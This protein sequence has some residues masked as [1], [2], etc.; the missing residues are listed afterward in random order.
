MTGQQRPSLGDQILR[1]L[2]KGLA[3]RLQEDE[4]GYAELVEAGV[5]DPELFSGMAESGDLKGMLKQ[6]KGGITD[7]VKEHPSVLED[8]DIDP[9]KVLPAEP[10]KEPAIQTVSAPAGATTV[11]RTIAFSDLEG[12][13]AFTRERGDLEASAVLTDHYV[14]VDEIAAGRGGLV[15]KR[16][17]DGHMLSFPQ[18]TAAVLAMIEL[19]DEGPAALALRAGAHHGSVI[20]LQEDLFGDVVNVAARVTDLADGGEALVTAAIRDRAATR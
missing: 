13:T 18:P 3:T 14:A 12:F 5:I 9:L 15:V 10:P 19:V 16:L 17:G 2:A 6:L 20:E 11:D 8:L 4:E 7:M 1:R